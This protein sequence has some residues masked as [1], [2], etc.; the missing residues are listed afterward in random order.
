MTHTV[1]HINASAAGD[2]SV[3]RKATAALVAEQA[4]TK[5]ITRDVAADPLPY[6]SEAWANAR[7]VPADER[8][9]EQNAILAQ[10]DMLVAELQAADTIV[11]GLPVYNFGIPASLKAWVDLVARPKLTFTYT[12]EGPK[13]LL[14]G[15]KAIVA[16]AAGGTPIGAP[17]DYASTHMT[18]ILNFLGITDVTVINAKEYIA[19]D[20]A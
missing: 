15:K 3:S 11:V 6:V 2:V 18:H 19:A 20:V 14:T 7:I 16:V 4:A 8:S 5:V 13:G 12:A 9:A 17:Y 1:L 10:S